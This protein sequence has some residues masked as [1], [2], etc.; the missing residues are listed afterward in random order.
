[1]NSIRQ[2]L[3]SPHSTFFPPIGMSQK[4]KKS[5]FPAPKKLEGL[6]TLDND[7]TEHN[8]AVICWNRI[9]LLLYTGH[10]SS[11]THGPCPPFPV[12]LRA[13]SVCI[14]FASPSSIHHGLILQLNSENNRTAK[15]FQ[16]LW[17]EFISSPNLPFLLQPYNHERLMSLKEEKWNTRKQLYCIIFSSSLEWVHCITQFSI[18]YNHERQAGRQ[19]SS[20]KV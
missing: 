9:Q 2:V 4:K 20:L 1:M 6:A 17:N 12:V 15:F 11:G 14:T 18:P 3:L 10:T 13:L 5:R 19:P 16:V 7:M 8:K